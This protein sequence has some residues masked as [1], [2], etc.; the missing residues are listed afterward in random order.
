MIDG[1]G[2]VQRVNLA[3][4]RL[5]GRSLAPQKET[6]PGDF[7][8]CVHALAGSDQCGR[9]IHC[10]DCPIRQA[11][12]AVVES[13]RPVRDVAVEIGLVIDGRE[14]RISLEVGA[15][16]LVL[17]DHRFALLSLTDVTERLRTE[18][19]L[20]ESEAR[21][22]SAFE[23]GAVAMALT[24]PDASLIRV[25]QAFCRLVD[26]REEDLVGRS[27]MEL[28]HPDDRRPTRE[29]LD[30]V[31]RDSRST[32]RFEKRYLRRDGGILWVDISAAPVRDDAGRTLYLVT[33]VQDI[34]ERK[35]AEELL[36][37]AHDELEEKV[38]GRTDELRKANQTLQL[39]STCNQIMVRATQ[40]TD[41]VREICEAIV[42]TE[43]YVMAWVGYAETG[44]EKTVRP[45]AAAGMDRDYLADIRIRWDD[46]E[47]GRGP[48]G[49]CIRTGQVRFG[50]DF[51][52]D[53]HSGGVAGGGIEARL[54]VLDRRSPHH[55]RQGLRGA[56]HLCP[57][58]GILRPTPGRLAAGAGR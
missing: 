31:V 48:T 51:R 49:T 50:R 53:P 26:A 29:A 37:R 7:L 57:G 45:V 34:T 35:R 24:A 56:H 16:P 43:G 12:E 3:A 28:T 42:T 44:A 19:A 52:T 1:E 23:E 41:L 5:T 18:R 8:G 58:T 55:E 27:I 22:R 54:P 4:S 39:I 15:D 11:F 25:N 20:A 30:S 21:F 46:V 33:H 40:E 32:L 2:L 9:T 38:R 14:A 10:S 13:G 17:D 47:E 36:H 6:R